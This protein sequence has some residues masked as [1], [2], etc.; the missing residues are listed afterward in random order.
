[1]ATVISFVALARIATVST[2]ASS[3]TNVSTSSFAS[4]AT[5]SAAFVR[6]SVPM[7]FTVPGKTFS[8]PF[9]TV[10]AR[11]VAFESVSAPAPSFTQEIV[12]SSTAPPSTP[13]ASPAPKV[14]VAGCAGA[15]SSAMFATRDGASTTRP[16]T[17]WSW[18]LRLSVT[19][20]PFVSVRTFT[21]PVCSPHGRTWGCRTRKNA[22][23]SRGIRTVSPAWRQTT[24][25]RLS[26][27]P[28]SG[29]WTMK[30]HAPSVTRFAFD[31]VFPKKFQGVVPQETR[32]IGERGSPRRTM[33][34]PTCVEGAN[35][36]ES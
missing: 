27:T 8:T 15:P 30:S 13:S 1:M 25:V 2:S 23:L 33:S 9:V 5:S 18:P 20:V 11:T 6:T 3:C 16:F 34:P 31:A 7:R 24:F 32:R 22:P 10:S 21:T 12:S 19:A 4:R 36:L 17:F 35:G 26:V 29:H 28:F 14:S